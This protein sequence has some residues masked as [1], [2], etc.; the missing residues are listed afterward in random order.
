[1]YPAAQPAEQPTMHVHERI[2][3]IQVGCA[4]RH[5]ATC[6]IGPF[7]ALS[8]PDFAIESTVSDALT[9]IC[10]VRTLRTDAF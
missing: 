7:W 10:K 5:A 1:M 3:V 2:D 9:E 4:A 8:I 6:A